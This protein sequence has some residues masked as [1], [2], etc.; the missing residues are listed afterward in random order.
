MLTRQK[1]PVLDR[2][3][4]SAASG[5]RRGGYVLADSDRQRLE[6]ILIATG[7]EVSLGLA[8]HEQLAR[9][10]I[11]SRVVSMPCWELFDRQSQRYREDVLPP[12][13]RARVSIEAASPFGWERYVGTDGAIIGVNGFGASGPGSVVMREFGFTTEHLVKVAKAVIKR[14]TT[15]LATIN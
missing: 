15:R 1:V 9:D 2:S 4:L 8:A 6:V 14:C 13:V 10:G 12:T 7:S 3:R 11:G 5:L